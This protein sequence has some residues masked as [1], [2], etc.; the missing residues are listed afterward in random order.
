MC[1][2]PGENKTKKAGTAGL[3]F[4]S[5]FSRVGTCLSGWVDAQN[6][7]GFCHQRRN[8]S[9]N[10]ETVLK[11]KTTPSGR[12]EKTRAWDGYLRVPERGKSPKPTKQ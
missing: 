11:L 9:C 4:D 6:K 1:P 3:P 10:S 7:D 8:I 2:E 5:A 12:G